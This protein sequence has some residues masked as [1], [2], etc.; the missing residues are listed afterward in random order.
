VTEEALYNDRG[1]PPQPGDLVAARSLPTAA[2]GVRHFALAT[3]PGRVLYD[4][5]HEA[6]RAAGRTPGGEPAYRLSAIP[7]G[8]FAQ[9][10]EF[11]RT[12][13]R[14]CLLWAQREFRDHA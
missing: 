9:Y 14:A 4:K 6:E 10:V 13:N 7:A 5:S 11:L 1:L 3:Y 8:A 2:G 12:T